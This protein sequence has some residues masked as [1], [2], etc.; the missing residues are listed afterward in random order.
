MVTKNGL[1]FSTA[2]FL[3]ITMQLIVKNEYLEDFFIFILDFF[4][5][6]LLM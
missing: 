3:H 4:T 6:D 5:S 2:H 1:F